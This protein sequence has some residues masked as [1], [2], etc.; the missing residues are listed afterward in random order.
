GMDAGADDYLIKPFDAHELKVRLRAGMR[1][2]DLQREL[3][4]ARDA[5]RLQATR[6]PL[7][8]LLNRRAI[9]DALE[10]ELV[11]SRRE[12]TVLGVALADLDHFKQINDTHGHSAGDAVLL[13]ATRRMRASIR[14]YDEIGR[15]G[16]EEFLIVAPGCDLRCVGLVAERVRTALVASSMSVSGEPLVVTCSLGVPSTEE[17]P[18]RDVDWLIRA[19]DAALYR[20]KHAGRNLVAE[21]TPR[22]GRD[23]R[24]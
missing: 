10:S 16:G 11:R 7:T 5:L 24:V 14:P 22:D 4:V 17:H 18:G 2:L 1:I 23:G 21:A 20:A 8:G 15:Y 12:S 6:D 13:E 9:V 3:I 19:A